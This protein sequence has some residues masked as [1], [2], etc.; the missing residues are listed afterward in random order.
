[1]IK[2]VLIPEKVGNYYIFPKRVVG[3]DIEKNHVTATQVYLSGNGV[4]IER[5]VDQPLEI[6][7]EISHDEKVVNAIKSI[8]NSLDSF[9]EVYTSI[10]SSH[11]IFK[12]LRLP[13]IGHSKIKAVVNFEV[14]PLLPFSVDNAQID[15]IVTKEIKEDNSSEVMVAAAQRKA[16]DD[17]VALFEQA[18]VIPTKVVV[19]LFSL[20]SL[21][22]NIPEY[23][24]LSGNVVLVDV[25]FSLTRIAYVNDGR[26]AFVRT[27][28]KGILSQ[29]KVLAQAYS[30]SQNEAAEM[31]MRYGYKKEDDPEYKQ[32]VQKAA[33]PFWSDIK[34]TLQS[35]SSQ[36][37]GDVG[38][39]KILILGQGSKISGV[40]EFAKNFLS[41]DCDLFDTV[42]LVKKNTVKVKKGL[43][44]PSSNMVSLAV[45]FPSE[46][47][48]KFNLFK[49]GA[50][51][52]DAKLINKQLA[53]ALALI[54][55]LIGLLFIYSYLQVGKLKSEVR[56]SEKEVITVLN[57][58]FKIPEEDTDLEDVINGADAQVRRL[59]DRF[60]FVG[61]D[62][63]SCLKYLLALQ[64]AIADKEGFGIQ[65]E[66]I[67][68]SATDNK[69]MLKAKVKDFEA[70]K[71][72]VK[73]LKKSKLFSYVESPEKID[74]DMRIDLAKNV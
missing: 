45:A 52:K 66:S 46:I 43:Q 12:S 20:Y 61:K 11:V 31:M 39:S 16:V 4:K 56:E 19:D 58:T 53:T 13:F 2:N 68:I 41:I 62:R 30:V 70:L 25:G 73:E 26:L 60:S 37:G 74:F 33:S 17:H 22:K 48:G 3:F 36:L 9:D 34:F 1:M 32:A 72:L 24:N 55:I 18:G 63:F 67:T 6:N 69:I 50:G 35:F 14:E 57:K 8:F 28:P 7:G 42:S 44:I 65:V 47:I 54:L 27:L 23:E 51:I 10:S 21:Y 29:A 59:E 49:I 38:V 64:D 15:F 40:S 71:K 5:C